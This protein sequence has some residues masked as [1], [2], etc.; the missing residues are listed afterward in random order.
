[1]FERQ[2]AHR[3]AANALVFGER[4]LT[5]GELDVR[6]NRL[7]H[8]LVAAGLRRGDVVGV[9]LERGIEQ[10]IAVLAALKAGGTYT[11]LDPDLPA[12]R[13]DSLLAHASARSVVTREDLVGRLAEPPRLLVRLDIDAEVIA[14]R[15]GQGL[16]HR[17]GPQDAACVMFTSGSTGVPKGVVT[18]HRAITG[19]MLGQ[20]FADMEPSHVWLQCSPVSWDAFALELFGALLSGAVC[21]LQPGQRPEPALIASLVREHRV[22]TLHVSASLLNFLLDEHPATF[23]GLRQVMTGGEA[24]S[25][26]HVMRLVR[27]FPGSSWSTATRRSSRR[28]S[29]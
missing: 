10:V 24:A 9:Y 18:P 3:P 25:V 28:S 4:R 27:E 6:A 8:H 11:M 14:G 13:V 19:T 17:A 26:H 29:P 22:T 12:T 2:A 7:A 20:G 1:M 5:Y 16:G 23:T 21:V 15:S